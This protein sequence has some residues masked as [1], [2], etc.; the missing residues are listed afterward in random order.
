ME[1]SRGGVMRGLLICVLCLGVGCTIQ[2]KK[3]NPVWIAYEGAIQYVP[4]DIRG[5]V[6]DS[7]A[8]TEVEADARVRGSF[9]PGAFGM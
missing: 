4:T 8:K 3:Y 9:V 6:T 2:I 7:G 5:E 1:K